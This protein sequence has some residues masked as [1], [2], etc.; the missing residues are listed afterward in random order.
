MNETIVTLTGVVATVPEY[1]EHDG[2]PLLSFRLVASERRRD[3]RTGEWNNGAQTWVTVTCWRGLAAN[4]KDSIQA[5]DRIIVKGRLRTEEWVGQDGNRRLTVAVTADALGPDL[6]WG[7]TTFERSRAAEQAEQEAVVA[8]LEAQ[9]ADAP[10]YLPADLEPADRPAHPGPS[11]AGLPP[12]DPD[13][14]DDDLDEDEDEPVG[15]EAEGRLLV[16]AGKR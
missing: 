1:K 9:V 15:E 3:A 13:E 11:Y 7:T 8:R 4:A 10:V 6:N 2:T 14:E 5:K 16:G 12:R